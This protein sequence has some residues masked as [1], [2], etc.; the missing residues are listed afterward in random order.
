MDADI[1]SPK[2]GSGAEQPGFPVRR[3]PLDAP[4]DW[5]SRGWRDLWVELA[6][7]LLTLFLGGAGVHSSV[8]Q[9]FRLPASSCTPCSLRTPVWDFCSPERLR[10]CA[11]GDRVLHLQCG[12]AFAVGKEHRCRH[13]DSYERAGRASEYRHDAS[14]G[15]ANRGLCRVGD[16]DAVRWP[17]G[18]LSTSRACDLARIPSPR[19]GRRHLTSHGLRRQTFSP[20]AN[21]KWCTPKSCQSVALAQGRPSPKRAAPQEGAAAGIEI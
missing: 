12:C 17:R 16:L 11:C 2:Q 5:L 7:L 21:C 9:G 3:V 10:G 18:H 15:R 1:D 4:W 6:F 8:E 19:G 14:V 13:G 20:T